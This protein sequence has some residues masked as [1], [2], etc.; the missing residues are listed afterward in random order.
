MNRKEKI[1]LIQA[2]SEGKLLH[3][4]VTPARNYFF[5][6]SDCRTYWEGKNDAGEDAI[7]PN[8]EFE[9]LRKIINA[10]SHRRQLCGLETHKIFMLVNE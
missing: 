5:M 6:Q 3:A 10:A 4:D 8:A 7:Y 2:V 9:E 1:K